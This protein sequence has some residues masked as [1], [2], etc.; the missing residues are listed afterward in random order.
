M[1]G[2][3]NRQLGVLLAVLAI[4]FT[5]GL[6]LG[7][8]A[9]FYIPKEIVVDA[10]GAF[11]P[12]LDVSASVGEMFKENF[13]MESLWILAVWILGCTNLTAPLSGA[14]MSVRGFVIGF[15]VA[16]VLNGGNDWVKFVL[17]YIMPQCIAALPVMT[18]FSMQCILCTLEKKPGQG[19]SV[20]YFVRGALFVGIAAIT[21][22][23]EAW[24]AILFRSCL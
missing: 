17:C 16:F 23:A 19:L 12:A 8:V 10:R 1:Y 2:R 21:A 9:L 4:V 13:M 6:V 7:T 18:V 24:L 5:L 20:G 15:S 22:I 11:E 14:V 3:K